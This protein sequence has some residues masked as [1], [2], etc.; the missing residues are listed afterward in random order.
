MRGSRRT[1]TCWRLPRFQRGGKA[2]Q[3]VQ[4]LL[5]GAERGGLLHLAGQFRKFDL[6]TPDIRLK[7]GCL[8]QAQHGQRR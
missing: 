7:S 2:T 8:E 4:K 5:V 3:F 1:E 6:E